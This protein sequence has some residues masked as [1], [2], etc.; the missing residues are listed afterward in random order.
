MKNPEADTCSLIPTSKSKSP[1]NGL[2]VIFVT[3]KNHRRNI[4]LLCSR[5]PWW[6]VANHD[7]NRSVSR[8]F[9]RFIFEVT[10]AQNEPVVVVVVVGSCSYLDDTFGSG[11]VECSGDGRRHYHRLICR[12]IIQNTFVSANPTCVLIGLF[13]CF[14]AFHHVINVRCVR[15]T[16]P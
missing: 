10:V 12:S 7:Y 3:D 16:A 1:K 11:G 13:P 2:W 14:F 9:R 8:D 5:R 6:S 4:F 15:V